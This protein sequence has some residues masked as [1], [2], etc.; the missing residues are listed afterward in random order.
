MSA[1]SED[2]PSSA[3]QNPE[4]GLIALRSLAADG[5]NHKEWAAALEATHPGPGDTNAAFT[6]GSGTWTFFWHEKPRSRR[7]PPDHET[8]GRNQLAEVGVL[9]AWLNLHGSAKETVIGSRNVRRMQSQRSLQMLMADAY[10]Q[11]KKIGPRSRTF[12]ASKKA[13]QGDLRFAMISLAAR[14]Q[15]TRRQKRELEHGVARGSGKA[16]LFGPVRPEPQMGIDR[17][18]RRNPLVVRPAVSKG[19]LGDPILRTRLLRPRRHPAALAP[20][21]LFRANPKDYQAKNNVASVAMLLYTDTNRAHALAQE[22]YQ[23]HGPIP[24]FRSTT[25]AFSLYLL[26]QTAE[27]S[28]GD[29]PI[30][31][32]GSAPFLRRRLLRGRC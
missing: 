17:R 29:A 6:D 4:F 7:L 1:A 18:S 28:G 16:R 26:G 10:I 24:W 23:E 2:P 3:E 8:T 30:E 15:G 14:N 5:L 27:A 32:H 13:D 31:R 22:I 25:Y 21:P 12:C 19:A 11:Q 9:G 20:V